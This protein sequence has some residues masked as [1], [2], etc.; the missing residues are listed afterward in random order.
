[1]GD[2]ADVWKWILGAAL[3]LVA[4]LGRRQLEAVE[5][6]QEQFQAELDDLRRIT[7]EQASNAAGI[8]AQLSGIEGMLRDLREDLR[9][10]MRG[11]HG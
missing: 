3:G 7:S 1:M 11:A 10:Y 9:S 6:R 8:K 4:W 2:V 5:K